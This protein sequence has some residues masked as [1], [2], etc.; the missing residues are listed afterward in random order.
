MPTKR[1]SSVVR[2]RIHH[3][4]TPAADEQHLIHAPADRAQDRVMQLQRTVGNQAT[5]ALVQEGRLE[6]PQRFDGL[7]PVRGATLQRKPP[8]ET[9]DFGDEGEVITGHRTSLGPN[10]DGVSVNDFI[11]TNIVDRVKEGWDAH[12]TSYLTAINNFETFMDFPADKEAEPDYVGAA[13][14]FGMEQ[15]LKAAV[16]QAK[17]KIPGLDVG[18]DFIKA[19]IA[20][21]E[22][23]ETAAGKIKVRDYIVDYRNK[24]ADM[25]RDFQKSV[26]GVRDKVKQGYA[27]KSAQ[28]QAL[29]KEVGG[30]DVSQPQAS[31]VGD[32]AV[33]GPAAKYLNDL[34][35]AADDFASTVPDASAYLQKMAEKW[36]NQDRSN[37]RSEG[38][39]KVFFGGRIY[40]TIKVYKDG[41][42][43]QVDMPE[44]AKLASDEGDKAASIFNKLMA[45]GMSINDLNIEKNLTIDVEDE[46]D[47]GFNDYYHYHYR[48][49]SPDQIEG[50]TAFGSP[51]RDEDVQRKVPLIK[52]AIQEEVGPHSLSRIR[53]LEARKSI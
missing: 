25:N 9:I 53:K 20:E 42:S 43:L 18:V 13:L 35:S 22:R 36:V 49:T 44:K 1:R 30:P 38:G 52:A 6:T 17:K 4:N 5:Q 19:M 41:D 39:G 28:S 50:E 26:G 32:M 34:K 8:T 37:I 40:V 33:A 51:I 48:F 7:P 31:D 24:V 46:V 27:A 47:W 12:I 11:D 16:D 2:R 21:G 3:S 45:E 29:A 10:I 15:L 23:A 14:K